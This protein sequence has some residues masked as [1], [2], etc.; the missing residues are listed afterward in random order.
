ME[1]VVLFS[2]LTGVLSF[3]AGWFLALRGVA[4]DPLVVRIKQD[5]MLIKKPKADHVLVAMP[6]S[7]LGRLELEEDSVQGKFEARHLYRKKQK[8]R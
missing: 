8:A 7:L 5:E 3:T 4:K 1:L 2:V 6:P